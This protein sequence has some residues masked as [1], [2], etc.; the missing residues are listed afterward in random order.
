MALG[1]CQR[2]GAWAW[3]TR[4][5]SI[6]SRSQQAGGPEA[7]ACPG[8][9]RAVHGC[10][11]RHEENWTP[12]QW[13]LAALG[14]GARL[15]GTCTDH[16]SAYSGGQSLKLALEW[17]PLGTTWSSK[18]GIRTARGPDKGLWARR[19]RLPEAHANSHVK[20]AVPAAEAAG[21][22]RR[23]PALGQAL[24]AAVGVLPGGSAVAV[25]ALQWRGHLST[26]WRSLAWRSSPPWSGCP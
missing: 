12:P 17:T 16:T 25:H 20:T 10:D 2:V 18:P 9:C 21:T 14:T 11:N 3:W 8:S 22:G 26:L 24:P 7:P 1:S 23:H 4:E 15:A 6:A 19:W 13:L 5:L